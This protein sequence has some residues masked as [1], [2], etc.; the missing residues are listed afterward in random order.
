MITSYPSQELNTEAVGV[1]AA[2]YL[3]RMTEFVRYKSPWQLDL[4][5]RD[6]SLADTIRAFFGEPAVEFGQENWK[7]GCL[8][9]MVQG[10]KI[11]GIAGGA[12]DQERIWVHFVAWQ[13]QSEDHSPGNGEFCI[14]RSSWAVD[15]P[16]ID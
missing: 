14:S 1:Y 11:R 3:P 12:G 2:Q 15:M 16:G 8:A 13:G 4:D 7:L 9:Q 5:V 10:Q 6:L